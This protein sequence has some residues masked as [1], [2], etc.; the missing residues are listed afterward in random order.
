MSAD[1]PRDSGI[2]QWCQRSGILEPPIE[3]VHLAGGRSN[4]TDLLRDGTGRT[5]ILRR[6]PE[7]GGQNRSRLILREARTLATLGD[8]GIPVPRILGRSDDA[9]ALGT[10]FYVMENVDGVVLR[11]REDAERLALRARTTAASS[12]LDALIHLHALPVPDAEGAGPSFVERQ[13]SYWDD[14]WRRSGREIPGMDDCFDRLRRNVPTGETVVLLHGDPH[15]DNAIF[16]PEGQVR[17][18]LDWELSSRGPALI[19]LAHL[20]LFWAEPGEI[21]FITRSE[22][23]QAEGFPS[24]RRLVQLYAERSGRSLV[25]LPFY[26]AFTA[27]RLACGMSVVSQRSSARAVAGPR[28][29]APDLFV[30]GDLPYDEAVTRLADRAHDLSRQLP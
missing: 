22:P 13:L 7:Q 26:E 27:W 21:P 11:S 14:T 30:E 15:L 1:T 25:N 3:V 17:A 10:P 4:R 2:D 20:L 24:R 18:L 9:S 28:A 19:D 23:S 8:H 6:P 5:A 16:H 29:A 12:F